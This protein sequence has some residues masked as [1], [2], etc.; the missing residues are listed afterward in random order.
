[1]DSHN[2]DEEHYRHQPADHL[3]NDVDEVDDEDDDDEPITAQQVFLH[4]N[5]HCEGEHWTVRINLECNIQVLESLKNAWLNER[6]APELLP[7]QTDM[8]DMMLGQIVHMDE[9]IRL[10]PKNDFRQIAHKMELERVKYII[11]SY[12]RCRLEKIERFAQAILAADDALSSADQRK[13]A[14]DERVFAT[15]FVNDQQKHFQQLGLQFMPLNLQEQS[16]DE[17]V[18]P[19]RGEHVFLKANVS[20][21]LNLFYPEWMNAVS[22]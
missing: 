13:L 9:N 22:I 7:H 1:M 10:L 18:R 12:L 5:I 8:L 4:T 2:S 11:N 3:H 15:T 20:G 14:P 17:I 19:N 16:A 6:H 21:M